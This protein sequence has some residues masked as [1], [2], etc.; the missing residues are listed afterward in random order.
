MPDGGRALLPAT[1][2]RGFGNVSG[3]ADKGGAADSL[4]HSMS[5]QVQSLVRK[6]TSTECLHPA[7]GRK[8]T[9]EVAIHANTSAKLIVLFPGYGAS[10]DAE[11]PEL[12]DR[13]PRRYLE[14]A[15]ALQE[16]QLGA[17]VRAPNRHLPFFRY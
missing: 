12:N 4:S 15:E 8:V 3:P 13:H 5:F 10:V 6:A 16:A 7:P 17:V 9:V 11:D 1:V 14:I 2:R